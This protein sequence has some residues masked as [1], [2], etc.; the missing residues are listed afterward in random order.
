[1][2]EQK[3]RGRSFK[4][5]VVLA[6]VAAVAMFVALSLLPDEQAA[7]EPMSESERAEMEVVIEE[8]QL[9]E[10]VSSDAI[11]TTA[12]GPRAETYF[13]RTANRPKIAS[14]SIN[15]FFDHAPGEDVTVIVRLAP[16]EPADTVSAR[17]LLSGVTGEEA[18]LILELAPVSENSSQADIAV[19][20]GLV[21][22]PEG[23][24]LSGL[25]VAAT[26]EAESSLVELRF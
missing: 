20:S 6:A 5:A 24:S 17:P 16:G 13:V 3:K 18:E 22:V 23:A 11:D 14:I 15:P 8:V 26:L 7:D 9:E 19:F 1:M 21:S 4:N 12:L 2:N 25:D 10:L